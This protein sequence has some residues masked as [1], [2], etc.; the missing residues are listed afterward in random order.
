MT[1]TPEQT[2]ATQGAVNAPV[3]ADGERL[4]THLRHVD[5]AVPDF[6]KQLAFYTETWGLSAETTDDGIA[7]LAAEGSPEQYS[8]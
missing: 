8:V 2:L 4:V 1:Q 3:G 6:D 5:L 7:F